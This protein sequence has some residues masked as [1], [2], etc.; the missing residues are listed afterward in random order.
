MK[1]CV[2]CRKEMKCSKNGVAAVW[3]KSHVY[4]GDEFECPTCGNKILVCNEKPY[5]NPNLQG[6]FLDMT[7]ASD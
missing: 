4:P 5:H 2:K 1:I 7:P 3:N 6:E